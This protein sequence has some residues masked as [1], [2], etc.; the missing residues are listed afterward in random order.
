MTTAIALDQEEIDLLTMA[1]GQ[2]PDVFELTLD[3]M[4]LVL[5]KEETDEPG[6]DLESG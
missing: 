1:K 5:R 6:Q 4:S 3:M 2:I